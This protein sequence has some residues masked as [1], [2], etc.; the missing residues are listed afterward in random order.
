MVAAQLFLNLAPLVG[1]VFVTFFGR[2]FSDLLRLILNFCIVVGPLMA[3][4]LQEQLDGTTVGLTPVAL[5]GSMWSLLA[6]V[7]VAYMGIKRP[8]FGR[9]L[10]TV[11]ISFLCVLVLN[12]YY[13]GYAHGTVRHTAPATVTYL[14]WL[15]PLATGLLALLLHF[16]RNLPGLKNWMD[17]FYMALAGG[18]FGLQVLCAMEWSITDGLSYKRLLSHDFGC[19]TTSC[20]VTMSVTVG[21]IILGT[22]M[23]FLFF[24]AGTK[25]AEDETWDDGLENVMGKLK[26]MLGSLINVNKAIR[27]YST[28]Y[29]ASGAHRVLHKLLPTGI[30]HSCCPLR[31]PLPCSLRSKPT[32]MCHSSVAIAHIGRMHLDHLLIALRFAE[33]AAAMLTVTEDIYKFI[34]SCA[35]VLLLTF[36]VGLIVNC[37]EFFHHDLMGQL[38][39]QTLLTVCMVGVCVLAVALTVAAWFLRFGKKTVA[40]SEW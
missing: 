19:S 27:L 25:G 21:L 31:P 4:S 10:E 18:F 34:G 35:D 3:G 6:G 24:R 9:K 39:A 17:S 23:Q 5:L 28:E 32:S 37:V 22:V 13:L 15:V 12:S 38:Q 30:S 1:C 40:S 36:S 33:A 14:E 11:G 29:S 16:V 2:M 26:S 8:A 20:Y 7:G